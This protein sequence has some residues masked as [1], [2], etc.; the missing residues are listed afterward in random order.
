[1]RRPLVQGACHGPNIRHCDAASVDY[2]EQQ[3]ELATPA[4]RDAESQHN[5]LPADGLS[6]SGPVALLLSGV[7]QWDRGA[8]VATRSGPSTL[9]RERH[10]RRSFGA[11]GR[12]EAALEAG[13]VSV[14]FRPERRREFVDAAEVPGSRAFLGFGRKS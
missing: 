5:D 10:G 1:M 8:P 14:E 2:R 13:A 9:D 11:T 4:P 7:L 3:Q 6:I 12:L